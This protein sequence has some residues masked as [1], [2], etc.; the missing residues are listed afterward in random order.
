V[1]PTR[2]CGSRR[3]G[4]T[5]R[6]SFSRAPELGPLQRDWAG[7]GLD[8]GWAVAVA[9]A[10]TGVLGS[11][12]ALVAVMTKE[13]WDLGLQRG[14]QAAAARSNVS[15]RERHSRSSSAA[16]SWIP[17]QVPG[18]DDGELAAA[19]ARPHVAFQVVATGGEARQ[20]QDG[21]LG[22]V[23]R[24]SAHSTAVGPAWAGVD[25]VDV[26][27]PQVAQAAVDTASTSDQGVGEP[28]GQ[29]V[30]RRARSGRRNF[31]HVRDPGT[32]AAP[33]AE[34]QAARFARVGGGCRPQQ[35]RRRALGEQHLSD[36][37]HG[38]RGGMVDLRAAG[39]RRSPRLGS[40][41]NRSGRRWPP[42]QPGPRLPR[43]PRAVRC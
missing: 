28:G 10:A 42:G 17:W 36:A 34:E 24:Q 31:K 6:R 13:S 2:R 21:R 3:S 35:H 29:N 14:L 23:R 27:F 39:R 15:P 26:P 11:W 43:Q 8:Q 25:R 4:T 22:R 19:D 1:T 18:L 30:V 20:E 38:R 9:H 16:T 40:A 12:G 32:L 33:W 7:R 5:A 37:R 41:S